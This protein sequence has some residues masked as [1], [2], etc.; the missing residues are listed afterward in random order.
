[1]PPTKAMPPHSAKTYSRERPAFLEHR[2]DHDQADRAA[3]EKREADDDRLR[4]AVKQRADGDREPAA[5]VP[6]RLLIAR[7]LAVP[8][9]E[10]GEQ[11]VGAGEDGGSR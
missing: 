10:T 7:A 8:R 11:P 2:G 9:A 3:F 5:F 4:D 6:P 1:M